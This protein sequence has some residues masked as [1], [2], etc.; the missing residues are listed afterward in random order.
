MCT[1]LY[2]YLFVFQVKSWNKILKVHSFPRSPQV[3]GKPSPTD[4]TNML[5]TSHQYSR[6]EPDID[7]FAL[8][9]KMDRRIVSKAQLLVYY[10][11]PVSGE[12]VVGGTDVSVEKCLPNK[13]G[14]RNA[15]TIPLRVGNC[16]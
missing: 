3:Q 10:V 5:G 2:T 1:T 14:G 8:K 6:T 7:T 11:L 15:N 9:V 4:A 12:V 16:I 13:V